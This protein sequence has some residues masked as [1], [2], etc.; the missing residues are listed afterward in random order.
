MFSLV[1][2]AA[3]PP[4]VVLSQLGKN[5][6]EENSVVENYYQVGLSSD[7]TSVEKAVVDL[8]DQIFSEPCFDTL[9]TKEQLGYTVASGVRHTHG[10]L[11]FVVVVQSSRHPPG[12][13][14]GRIEAF[15]E[16]FEAVRHGRR[17]RRAPPAASLPQTKKAAAYLLAL[18]CRVGEDMRCPRESV[19]RASAS[20]LATHLTFRCIHPHPIH[21][22]PRRPSRRSRRRSSRSTG[23]R[24]SPS[25]CR[26]TG[27]TSTRRT[28]TGRCVRARLLFLRFEFHVD[29][30]SAPCFPPS[31]RLRNSK[32]RC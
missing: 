25:S 13:V 29:A 27:R 15:L 18:S 17:K 32:L 14:D 26:R 3:F 20:F 19:A 2:L 7:A 21:I 9:R 6:A 23:P 5:A 30:E 31:A 4:A 24:S 16:A 8:L 1:T 28:G 12:F 22:P 10:V 11:G